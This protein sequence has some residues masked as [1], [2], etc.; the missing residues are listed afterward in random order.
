[1]KTKVFNNNNM[2]IQLTDNVSIDNPL[3]RS[4]VFS[5]EGPIENIDLDTHFTNS[6]K[7]NYNKILEKLE[8]F[9]IIFDF[10]WFAKFT[11]N[12]YNRNTVVQH[13]VVKS[14]N[15]MIYWR[16]YEGNSSGSG[17]NFIYIKGIKYKT[18][19][20]LNWDNNMIASKLNE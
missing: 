11:R 10:I 5:Y 9:N 13:F 19:D 3:N 18:T 2:K 1:M 14:N 4:D 8:H 15:D 17:G 16:K 20:F 12:N 7:K 6:Q